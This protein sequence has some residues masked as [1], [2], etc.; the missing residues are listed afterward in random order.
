MNS[1][2]VKGEELG[3]GWCEIIIEVPM[4]KDE[5][6]FKPYDRIRTIEDVVG[7]PVAWPLSLVA[8]DENEDL[9]IS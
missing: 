8:L 4:K 5:S 3:H 6:L 2:R 1:V 7:A 9:S